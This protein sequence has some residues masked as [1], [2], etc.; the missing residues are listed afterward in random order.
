MTIT[1]VITGLAT[2]GLRFWH[3]HFKTGLLEQ[4][5]RRK[6][7]F[8]AKQ[9]DKAGREQGD[10]YRMG[11]SHRPIMPNLLTRARLRVDFTM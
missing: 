9:I 5:E 8:W 4:I 2:A 10:F 1:R 11:S 3:I 6:A 7:D